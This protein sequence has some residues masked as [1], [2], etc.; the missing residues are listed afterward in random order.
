LSRQFEGAGVSLVL[1]TS[2]DCH[3][4]EDVWRA[5]LRKGRV[6]FC[7]SMKTR[8]DTPETGIILCSKE[9]ANQVQ[10]EK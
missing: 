6:F 9:H 4:A 1:L 2:R 8:V 10:R 7:T 3:L 5:I